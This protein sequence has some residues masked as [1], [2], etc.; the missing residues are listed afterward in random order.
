MGGSDA[1]RR[2]HVHDPRAVVRAGRVAGLERGE[3]GGEAGGEGTGDG[4][5]RRGAGDCPD[6][7]HAAV[8]PSLEN[9]L[10]GGGQGTAGEVQARVQELHSQAHADAV[11]GVP[12]DEE[13]SGRSEVPVPVRPEHQGSRDVRRGDGQAWRRRR[14]RAP[15]RGHRVPQIV[16]H[17]PHRHGFH[18]DG[19]A[20]FRSI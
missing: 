13:P 16:G 19:E 10:Q 11:I 15:R 17:H 2:L 3:Q 7:V 20:G 1:D 5:G 12:K 4:D 14:A 6:G 8:P 9:A 18:A